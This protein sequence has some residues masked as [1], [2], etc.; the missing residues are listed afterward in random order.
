MATAHR[1]N[2]VAIF[3][4]GVA[5]MT[6]A[7][8]LAERGFQVELYERHDELGGKARSFTYPGSGQDGRR[9]LPGTMGGHFFFGDAPNL[10]DTL[11]RISTGADLTVRD[12]LSTVRIDGCLEWAGVAPVMSFPTLSNTNPLI[13]PAA[14]LRTLAQAMPLWKALPASDIVLLSRKLAGLVASGEHRQW[15]QLEK[16]AFADYLGLEHLSPEGRKIANLPDHAWLADRHGASTRAVAQTLAVAAAGIFG[17]RRYGQPHVL[18]ILDGPETEVWFTPWQRQLERLGARFHLGHRLS[19]LTV[20]DQQIN[21][22]TVI[23]PN[24]E[25]LAVNADWYILA[26]PVDKAAELISAELLAADSNLG[27]LKQIP[28]FCGLNLQ[29][30]LRHRVSR[31]G[32]LFMSYSAPWGMGN[33]VLSRHWNLDLA[34]YGDGSARECLS[35]QLNDATW[36]SLPGMLYNK[37]AKDCTGPE[38]IDEVL[39]QMRRYLPDGETIFAPEAIHSV[40]LSPATPTRPD[41]LLSIDEPLLSESPSVTRYRPH[42][43]SQVTNLLL[44]G[45]YTRNFATGDQMEGANESGRRAAASI[46]AATDSTERPVQIESWTPPAWMRALWHYD[47]SR[48]VRG[49][50]NLFD[51]RNVQSKE[52]SRVVR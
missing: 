36:W 49:K 45:A 17:R 6:A 38:I 39:A 5:G 16:L 1:R 41:G 9:D 37:P 30:F 34:D 21:G 20:I 8:E 51:T 42:G 14:L 11:A 35:V 47:D 2:R 3:G 26:V 43:K 44:A 52:A 27:C 50:R 32:L 29:I 13:L 12:R 7:H 10:G 18:S 31:L 4:G 40:R 28:L 48:Y 23:T 22:A 15:G 25:T 24:D 33:E 46:L 19:E